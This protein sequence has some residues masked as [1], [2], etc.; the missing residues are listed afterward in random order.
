[1]DDPKLPPSDDEPPAIADASALFRDEPQAKEPPL[2][3]PAGAATGE[4]YE[5]DASQ[6]PPVPRSL[7]PGD[8]RSPPVAPQAT[9][10]KSAFPDSGA[11]EA[12]VEPVWTRTAEWGMTLLILAATGVVVLFLIYGLLTAEEYSLAFLAL[13][14]GGLTLVVLSYPIL[15]TLERPVRVTPE[16]AV[17]DYYTALSHHLPHYRRMW[18]LLSNAGKFGGPFATFD[19]FRNYWKD[20]L[21]QFRGGHVSMVTPLKFLVGDFKAAK[22][23]GLSEIAVSF[24]VYVFVRGKQAAGPVDSIRVETTLVKGPDKMWYLDR[25]TLP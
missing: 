23:A 24:V 2:S 17:R 16:Q 10:A 22:S 11:S 14:A 21:A 20:R 7:P 18:L 9:K 1:V 19:G 6:P 25:G 4:A 8:G 15:V 13:V 3:S 5:V 12:A